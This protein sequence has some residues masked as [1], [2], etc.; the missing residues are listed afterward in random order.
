MMRRFIAGTAMAVALALSVT[1][2]AGAG[3]PAGVAGSAIK[4][5]A[6]QVLD[7]AADKTG[8][9]DSFKATLSAQMTGTSEGNGSMTGSMQYRTK[10][11]LAYSIAFDQITMGGE[12]VPG[13]VEMRLVDR[14][15]YMKMPMLTELAGPSVKP[16]LKMSFDDVGKETGV[17]V[18]QLLQ[19]TKQMDPVQQTRM[20]T[21][22]KD[23]REVGKETVDGVETTRYTGTFRVEDAIAA[24][25]ADQ[26]ELARKSLSDLGQGS[27]NFDLWA[28]DQQLPRQMSLN[29]VPIPEGGTMTMKMKLSGFGEPVQVTAPPAGETSDLADLANGAGGGNPPRS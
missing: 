8:Q 12:S 15:I 14:A 19:Q 29:R 21:A 26:R 16:W 17:N 22:S 28:D 4:L 5:T 20:L 10:P 1:G 18:D 2:C 27:I 3:D 6:A 7:R 23:V 13:G 9:V 25:P 24:L 11:T